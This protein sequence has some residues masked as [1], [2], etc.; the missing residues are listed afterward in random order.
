MAAPW[1]APL[2]LDD[3]DDA[4]PIRPRPRS[5]SRAARRASPRRDLC[6]PPPFFEPAD[7]DG[8][9]GP[10]D[11]EDPRTTT[12]FHHAR[13]DARQARI[14]PSRTARGRRRRASGACAGIG[15]T[16]GRHRRD[17]SRHIGLRRRRGGRARVNKG[18]LRG[19]EEAPYERGRRDR[20]AGAA[21]TGRDR[22]PAPLPTA[23]A[24]T[25]TTSKFWGVSWHTTRRWMA[26]YSDANGKLRH[27]ALRHAGG[28]PH[29]VNARS[30]LP[31]TSK[32]GNTNPVV[33]GQLVPK[34][35]ARLA[36]RARRRAT[37]AGAPPR[38]VNKSKN[39]ILLLPRY[40][41]L[42]RNLGLSTSGL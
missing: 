32:L 11:G 31:P 6:A 27:I 16:C 26:N 12:K 34:P 17:A 40:S 24:S 4:P 30:A 28:R 42:V 5:A 35:C 29:A 38:R 36:G 41:A 1:H 13:P 33:D 7:D 2:E 19:P 23:R 9:G 22:P 21:H 25:A 14:R 37:P 39:E 18:P 15:N 10:D 20:R 8:R 3:D